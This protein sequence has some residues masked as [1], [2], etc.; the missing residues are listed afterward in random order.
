MNI[1]NKGRHKYDK[2]NTLINGVKEIEAKRDTG[3][4][5]EE[6]YREEV[7]KLE[8]EISKEINLIIK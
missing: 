5:T 6:E 7:L 8:E 4:Y 2:L 1:M 3:Y